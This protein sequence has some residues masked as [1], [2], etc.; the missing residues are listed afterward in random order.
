MTP[1]DAHP[2]P[3]PWAAALFCAAALVIASAAM[4]GC[5]GERSDKPPRQFF[6]DMDDQFKWRQ[7]TESEFF[8][9]GR[10]L[11]P[12]VAGTVAFGRSSRIPGHDAWPDFDEHRAAFLR[13]DDALYRGVDQHGDLLTYMPVP[14]TSDLIL[15][16]QERFNIFCAVCHGYRGE[17]AS[18][19]EEAENPWGGLVGRRWSI[20]IPGFHDPKYINPAERTGKDGYIFN[21]IRHGMPFPNPENAPLTMPSYGHAIDPPDAWAIVAYIRALQDMHLGVDI[22]QVP[23]SQRPALERTRPQTGGTN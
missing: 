16:G 23:E 3:R 22:Q 17:G 11:R 15:R 10:T 19:G 18:G 1:R 13:E 7:Q 6:P 14:V 21:V 9:D 20:P 5:R 8:A 12:I 4:L 2:Q